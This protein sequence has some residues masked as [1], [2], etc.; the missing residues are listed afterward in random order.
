[1]L[2]RAVRAGEVV[3]WHDVAFDA[4]NQAISIRREMEEM[5]REKDSG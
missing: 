4:E 2:K 5:F 1:V 3:R